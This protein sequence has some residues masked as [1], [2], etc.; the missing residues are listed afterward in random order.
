MKKIIVALDVRDKN[1][2][3]D[4][5]RRTAP[6][7]DLFKVGPILYLKYGPAVIEEIG[8]AG[9]EVFLD[10]KFHDI[11]ATVQ[12][13]VKSAQELGIYSLTIHS[14]GGADMIRA[15]VEVAPRPKIW[16]VTILTSQAA[17]PE[18][19]LERARLAKTGGT[20]GVI[21]SPL[22]ITAIKTACGREFEVVTPGIRLADRNDDQKRIATPF[23]AVRAGADFI[24]VGRPIIEAPDPAAAAQAVFN[25]L[26][27]A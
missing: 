1:A 20:D 19:V 18:Q 2:A 25:D 13:A 15:A 21:A 22:E 11:P 10:L 6:W 8:N 4:L 5:V 17:T 14:A 26:N 24:V 27:R 3:L 12:R 23:A 9:K 16:A 7:V